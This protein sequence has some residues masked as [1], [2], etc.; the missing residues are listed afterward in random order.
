ML[1]VLLCHGKYI[2]GICQE[3]ISSFP[4]TGHILVLAFLEVFQ[5]ILKS[6]FAL[7]P[8]CLVETYWFPTAFG[9]IFV[10]ETILND[11]KLQLSHG[12][13]EF[14]SV[15]LIDK[16]LSHSLVHQL[17]YTLLQ[18][19]GLHGIGI[20]NVFEHLGRERRQS[21]IVQHFSLRQGISYLEDAIVRQ[22]Y[23]ISWPSLIDGLLTL[24]HKLGWTTEA[25][26]LTQALMLIGSIAHKLS[27]TDLAKGDTTA[28]VGID[29]GCYLEDKTAELRFFRTD[30]T[31]HCLYGAWAGSYLHEAVEQLLHTKIIQGRAEEDGSHLGRKILLNGEFWI[32]TIDEFQI[33]SQLGSI[34]LAY[35]FL[36]LHSL[37]VHFHLFRNLLFVGSE[38]IETALKDI[39]HALEA[40]ALVDGP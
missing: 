1:E 3:D 6:R 5:F 40:H 33:I 10:F 13:Y 37:N 19:L 31:F 39:V 27:G 20:L 28:M 9:S 25:H 34:F 12:T 21:L 17:S 32:D 24:S 36:Q 26:G 35:M 23:D 11:L 22:A 38:E 15:E 16:E 30:H 2:S 7:H 29:V 14:A 18:L 8:A 4:V